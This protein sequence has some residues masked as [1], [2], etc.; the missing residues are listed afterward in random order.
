MSRTV[1]GAVIVG[2]I[3][4]G[5]TAA[6]AAAAPAQNQQ[7]QAQTPKGW[8]WTPGKN[9]ARVER[10][11]NVTT[12]PDGSTREVVPA[13]NCVTIKEKPAP[14]EYRLSSQCNKPK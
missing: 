9:G 4:L 8:N 11:S 13:G 12:N 10:P 2:A 7:T 3:A 5:A 1:I 14:G 6:Y